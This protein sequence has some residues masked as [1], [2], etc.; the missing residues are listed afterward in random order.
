MR[1]SLWLLVLGVLLAVA[2]GSYAANHRALRMAA[3]CYASGLVAAL[4]AHA[5]IGPMPPAPALPPMD[6]ALR[7]ERQR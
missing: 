2:L 7:R 4:I 3:L 5:I 6:E 1:L